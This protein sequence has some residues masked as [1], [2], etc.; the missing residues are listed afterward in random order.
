MKYL[1]TLLLCLPVALGNAEAPPYELPLPV[2]TFAQDV[3]HPHTTAQGLPSNDVTALGMGAEGN[4]IAVTASGAARLAGDR[5]KST[6]EIAAEAITKPALSA[7]SLARLK[8]FACEDIAVRSV[9]THAGEFAVAADSGL[10]VGDGRA[11]RLALPR[12]GAVR[13]APVDVRAVAY[14]ANGALWF[15]APQGVGQRIAESDWRLYTGAEG[16]P[17]NDFT[18]M[19]AGPSG[20]WFGTTNG[21]IRFQDGTFSFRQGGRWLLDNHVRDIVVDAQ[22]R[23]WIAT[24]RGVSCI[25]AQPMTLAEKAAFYEAEIEKY[26]RRTPFGFVNPADLAA[27]GDKT[28]ATPAFTDNDGHNMG[29]YLG[30]VGLGY[31]ATGNPVL[32]TYAHNAFRALA[33]LSEVT[34]GG[35]HP[36]PKGFIARAV[37]PTSGP[38]PNPQFDLAYDLK[39]NERDKLWKIIQPRWPID[40]TGEWYWKN[41]SS[42]DEVDGHFFGYAI[43]FDRVCTTEAEKDAVRV[44]VR[45]MIDHILVHGYNMVDYD[46]QPTR[47]GHFSPDDLNRNEAW[48]AER[49]L[50]SF[51][52]LTY[53]SIAHHITGDPKY[54]AAYLALALD[55]GYGMNGMTQPR[56]TA[57]PGTAG[58]PDDNM[59]FMNY[60]HLIRYESDPKLLS[61]YHHA[62]R[63]H[64]QLEQYERSA[65]TNFIHAACCM[66]RSR[67]DQWG[68]IDLTPPR[69]SLDAA[70]DTLKRFPLDLVDWPMSNA[71]RID[72]VRLQGHLDQSTDAGHGVDGNV[73]PIDERYE[74]AWDR[75]FWFLT[76]NGEGKTLRDG[77]HYLLAYYMGL[78]H[79]FIK[80]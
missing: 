16:L 27:T 6:T 28:S 38:D 55:H 57:G 48:C 76:Y 22:G 51:S 77:T 4:L 54:R 17:F 10:Y 73:F 62:I 35:T 31:A 65:F 61:M 36:A 56:E 11:W 25:A 8:K 80:E 45:S 29:M 39:R 72:A 9:A 47:W 42:S 70:I 71:H 53:L 79:G 13:W 43:Y 1:A 19:A 3:H 40:A 59:A 50:N 33:F 60:Y 64:W 66:G 49:G 7:R 75:D 74:F 44:V 14:D 20:V 21:A 37:M 46:G 34:Q 2:G 78:A 69:H 26:H 32:R 58:Q 5:W 23:A 15:A 30:A 24:A 63:R 41:D 52:I 18:C 67:T 68:T 12:Q